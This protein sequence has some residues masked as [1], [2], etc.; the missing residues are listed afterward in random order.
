MPRQM[1]PSVERALTNVLAWRNQP[2][3]ID[4]YFTIRDALAE[5]QKPKG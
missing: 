5:E 3:P 2:N 1:P 4:V